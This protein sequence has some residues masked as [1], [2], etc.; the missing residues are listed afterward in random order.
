MPQAIYAVTV[1]VKPGRAVEARENL[2]E[3][4]QIVLDAGTVSCR[5]LNNIA[6]PAAPSILIASAANSLGEVEGSM[7]AHAEL[8][9]D[10][11]VFAKAR[12]GRAT[13]SE[14][15]PRTV[16]ARRVSTASPPNGALID[17]TQP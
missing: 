2:M 7:A 3:I 15:P 9:V 10:R 17:R 16:V 11:S 4:K 6:G 13:L 12:T 8:L 14:R 1:R 5:L